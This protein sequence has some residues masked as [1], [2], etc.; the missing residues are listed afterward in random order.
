MKYLV[1]TLITFFTVMTYAQ[2]QKMNQIPQIT[3]SGEGK[4]KIVPDQG[5]ISLGVEN[6]GKEAAEV[7]KANDVIIDKILKF[8]KRNN[9]PSTDFQTTNVSLNKNYDYEKKKYNYVANQT[10]TV[11]LKDLSK[12]NEF[13]MGITETGVTNING[14]EFKSSKMETY[15]ADARKKAILNAKQKALDY[16]SV[17]NQKIGKALIISDN[18][19]PYYPQ[20]MFK[21]AMMSMR[22]DESA[23]KETLAIGEI[24]IIAN[25]Q[26]T[27][28]LE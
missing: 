17:L 18:S 12:Y 28:V 6:A 21:G 3:V 23:P 14:V 25:V 27:F 11:T 8:I 13:M 20:P 7:K 26:V 10:V 1:V 9:I 2:D 19:Q 24:E 4:I 5:I 16:V 15:E 22:A